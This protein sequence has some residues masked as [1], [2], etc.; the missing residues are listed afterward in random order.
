M[1]QA[2]PSATC[3]ASQKLV[4]PQAKQALLEKAEIQAVVGDAYK[5]ALGQ[6]EVW[7]DKRWQW[8]FR[9][10][11]LVLHDEADKA[12]DWANSL[13]SVGNAVANIDPIY[14]SLP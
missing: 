8:T 13:K 5:A 9:G 4:S 12:I 2:T 10:Q 1:S 3:R 6:K 14:V 7:D 11:K